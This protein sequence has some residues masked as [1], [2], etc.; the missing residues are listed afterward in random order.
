MT[1]ALSIGEDRSGKVKESTGTWEAETNS[2]LLSA[3]HQ[4]ATFILIIDL[5]IFMNSYLPTRF[6][7]LSV[8]RYTI[9]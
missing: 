7:F 4:A 9:F 1:S 2:V 5:Y 6:V 3:F 8:K